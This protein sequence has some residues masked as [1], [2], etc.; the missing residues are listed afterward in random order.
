M[1]VLV[2]GAGGALGRALSARLRSDPGA[3]VVLAGRRVEGLA[4]AI[5]LDVTDRLAVDAAIARVQPDLVFHAAGSFSGDF[6]A[7]LA[8][9]AWSS[10]H[11]LDATLAHRPQARVVLI[12]SAAEYGR[13]EA[14]DNPVPETRALA[15]VSVYGCTKAIQTQLASQYA[16]ERGANVVIA[17]LFNLLADGMSQRLFV[18]RVQQ[19]MD[20]VRRGERQ[21][22][23]LGTLDTQRDYVDAA[24]AVEQLL[25][26]ARRGDVGRVYHVGSGRPLRVRELLHRMLG[27]HGLDP[28]IV[29][30]VAAPA[31]RGYDAPIIYADITRTSALLARGH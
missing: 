31:R 1:R 21:R 22:I 18:G 7:D 20:Q 3:D 27:E 26:I 16:G 10:R 30:E 12:G 14:A 13:I 9:N 11:L 19:Q 17:R 24:M 23:E 6:D 15:P 28:A 8:V 25:A 29:D 5:R 2:T 4:G